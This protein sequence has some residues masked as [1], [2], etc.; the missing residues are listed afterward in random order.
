MSNGQNEYVPYKKRTKRS[1]N[2]HRMRMRYSSRELCYLSSQLKRT[3]TDSYRI[4]TGCRTH[5]NRTN[6]TRTGK[7]AYQRTSNVHQ[8]DIFIRWRPFEVL[9][10]SKT[11]QRIGPDKTD[12]TWHGTHSPHEELTRNACERTRMDRE[13]YCPLS[14]VSAIRYLTTHM[15]SYELTNLK[16]LAS[17]CRLAG[18]N[19]LSLTR[20][21]TLKICFLLT[22]LSYVR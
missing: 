3:S 21:R 12:I 1:L 6:R 4:P 16:I 17:I 19:G 7:T 13:F 15:R 9:N 14:S 8:P 10:M 2:D 20:S 11:C 18:A 22:L 5:E